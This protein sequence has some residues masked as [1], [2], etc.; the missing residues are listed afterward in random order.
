MSGFRFYLLIMLLAAFFVVPFT[1]TKAQDSLQG[2][3]G[4]N[5]SIKVG[6]VQ[7]QEETI[8]IKL[9]VGFAEV[10]QN[11]LFK[12][13]RDSTQT[14]I[15]GFSYRTGEKN[16]GVDNLNFSVDSLPVEANSITQ[17]SENGTIYWKLFQGE[18]G[19][20]QTQNVQVNH[21]QTN[22]ANLRGM[23]GFNYIIKD[24]LPSKIGKLN[25]NLT[26]MDDINPSSFNKTLNPDLDLKLEPFGWTANNTTL[27]WTWQDL[28]PAFNIQANFYWS[29]GDL[30]KISDLNQPISLYDIKTNIDQVNS[31]QISDSSYLTSWKVPTPTTGFIPTINFD[32]T[33]DR[34]IDN[35][36]IL[37]GTENNDNYCYPKEI[38]IVFDNAQP[39]KIVLQNIPTFQ[40][41]K[42]KKSVQTKT[43]QIKILSVHPEKCVTN[44][45]I[46]SEI[47][48]NAEP[49]NTV[50]TIT[51]STQTEKKHVF[52]QFF[53]NIW[54]TITTFF[55][56]LF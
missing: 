50:K 33:K 56:N 42:L 52:L 18:I 21:W 12:N 39:E 51:D 34:K 28:L 7:L 55:K 53:I 10:E 24:K 30:A 1:I 35:L 29:R 43:V 6:D 48:F 26:L 9:H 25:L 54:S 5:L 31:Y 32:F 36:S 45:L 46:I 38:E 20:N 16:N 37:A 4:S 2:G 41:V 11:Y 49:E 17:T 44:N 19:P 13:N 22:S 40:E 3:V 23:R 8:N 15:Y 27:Q 47:E 14:V